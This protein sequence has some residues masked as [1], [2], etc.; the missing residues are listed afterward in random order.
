M[1]I[2]DHWKSMSKSVQKQ[3]RGKKE[4]GEGEERTKCHGLPGGDASET[5]RIR[6]VRLF[7]FGMAKARKA[8]SAEIRDWDDAS[9]W[10]V[11]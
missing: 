4:K 1:P 10:F 3:E 8:V 6:P 9:D 11:A 7:A 2:P 5:S